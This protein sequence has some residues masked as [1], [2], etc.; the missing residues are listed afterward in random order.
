M[1]PQMHLGRLRIVQLYLGFDDLPIFP[2]LRFPY[3][4]GDF[5]LELLDEFRLWLSNDIPGCVVDQFPICI[6][7]KQVNIPPRCG[8]VHKHANIATRLVPCGDKPSD[9]WFDAKFIRCVEFLGQLR[10][11]PDLSEKLD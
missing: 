6:S 11:R 2:I 1:L 3:D 10:Y 7:L 8:Y 5:L 9:F 4:S